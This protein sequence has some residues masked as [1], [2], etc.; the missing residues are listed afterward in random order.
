[1]RNLLIV[2]IMGIL[3]LS[4]LA[5]FLYG[6]KDSTIM[7]DSVKESGFGL[8]V[9]TDKANYASGEPVV[10]TLKVFNFTQEKVTFHFR[11]AQR[12]DFF[13][14]SEEGKELWRWS[15]GRMFAQVLGEET[16]APGREEITYTASYK[17][18]LE[19]GTYKI[20]G[21]LVDKEKPM[22]GSITIEV[23]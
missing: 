19:P 2:I 6:R 5:T 17:G 4:T 13:I 1:M 18:K 21:I 12:F 15:D 3:G 10:I 23:K 9:N 7:K 16:L 22:S 20:T 14:E 11:N 8:T